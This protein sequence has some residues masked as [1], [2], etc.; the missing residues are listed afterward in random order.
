MTILCVNV[1]HVATLR[2]AR[3][4]NEPDPVTAALICE[5]A[6]AAGITLHV[7][8]D[9][10]HANER[11]LE[12]MMRSCKTRVNLEMAATE[13][14]LE[15]ARKYKPHQVTLVPEKREEV[16][17]E[18]GLDVAGSLKKMKSITE[19]L[20]DAG[21]RVSHFIDPDE[22]Q[23]AAAAETGAEFIE[24]HTG[25]YCNAIDENVIRHELDGL[26]RGSA[27]AIDLGLRVNAGHGLN[28]RNVRPVAVIKGMEELNIGHSII[29][30][31]VYVGIEKAVKEMN[32]LIREAVLESLASE[33]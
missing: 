27:L 18:G 15:V 1:D 19:A 4:I 11:D 6:G 26:I 14:M 24:L 10:R 5:L 16:T 9:R 8:E 12:L 17:T 31:S 33:K 25:S 28:Y 30:H 3:K 20:Q 32:A 21:I 2:E 29:A 22:T 7:R 13:K 23:I